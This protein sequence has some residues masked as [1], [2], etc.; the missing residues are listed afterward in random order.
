MGIKTRA[1]EYIATC[2]RCGCNDVTH[3]YTRELAG[4]DF[5]GRGWNV[6]SM[7]TICPKCMEESE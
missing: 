5:K 2:D 6:T 7:R 4:E 1:T 3:Q